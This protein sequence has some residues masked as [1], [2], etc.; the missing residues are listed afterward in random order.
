MFDLDA[1][2]TAIHA[3][4]GQDQ[5]LAPLL[6]RFPGIR[7]AGHWSLY[8][9]AIRGIVGQ[10]VSIKAARGVLARLAAAAGTAADRMLFPGAAALA[11]LADGHFPMPGRRRETLRT[12]CRYCSERE[13]EL[14]LEAVAAFK[15]V[16]PWTIAM[17]ALRGNG[18][19]DIFPTRDLGLEKAWARLP[20][21]AVTLLDHTAHW[22]PW[23]SYAAN[24]LWRSL[25]L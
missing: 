8:E 17:A 3:V 24:L 11:A 14:D 9:A 18:Q 5:R 4:L 22:R 6:R 12:L 16:G 1:N 13:D 19:P 15:G 21:P 20:G 23:R 25:S 2:P 7:S 10:Q